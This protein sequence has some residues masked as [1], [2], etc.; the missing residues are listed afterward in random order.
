MLWNLGGHWFVGL[1][2]GYLLCFRWGFGVTGLWWGLST[3]LMIC[4]VGL[5]AAWMREGI[6]IGAW[7]HAPRSDPRSAGTGH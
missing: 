4:G 6:R 2:L 5:L 3:G 1:P 7:R